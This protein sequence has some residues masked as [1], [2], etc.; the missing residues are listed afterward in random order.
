MSYTPIKTPAAHSG[1]KRGHAAVAVPPKGSELVRGRI[2]QPGYLARTSVW[3]PV[4]PVPASPGEPGDRAFDQS[5]VY[6]CVASGMWRKSSLSEWADKDS[7]GPV[8]EWS[9]AVPLVPDEPPD[10]PQTT[11]DVEHQGVPVECA[12]Q[13]VTRAIW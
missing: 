11:W 7:E 2:F 8:A 6:F 12:G 4:P 5:Y 13:P 3:R 1:S 10:E 9:G